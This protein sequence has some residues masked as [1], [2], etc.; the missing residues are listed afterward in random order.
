LVPLN[1]AR[2]VHIAKLIAEACNDI[3]SKFFEPLDV[4]PPHVRCVVMAFIT[5]KCAD[6]RIIG[7]ARYSELSPVLKEM[8]KMILNKA[9]KELEEKLGG[10]ADE[11][12]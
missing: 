6:M 9:A 7:L 11:D 4:E 10:E 5:D 3:L 12:A 8:Y 1:N 2:L